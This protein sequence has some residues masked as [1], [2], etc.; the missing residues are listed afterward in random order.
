MEDTLS[1]LHNVNLSIFNHFPGHGLR[2]IVA[3]L[4]EFLLSKAPRLRSIQIGTKLDS[5]KVALHKDV[6]QPEHWAAYDTATHP[7]FRI[8]SPSVLIA[9]ISVLSVCG[10]GD[11]CGYEKASRMNKFTTRTDEVQMNSSQYFVTRVGVYAFSIAGERV[12]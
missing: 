7:M 11:H 8:E 1:H 10:E 3:S 9:E 2:S 4:A 6:H 5:P 12:N